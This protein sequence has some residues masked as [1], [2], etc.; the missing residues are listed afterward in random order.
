MVE[1]G[2]FFCKPSLRK[3]L[4]IIVEEEYFKDDS[5]IQRAI[6]KDHSLTG[7]VIYYNSNNIDHNKKIFFEE[8]FNFREKQK[9][10]IEIQIEDKLIALYFFF[11]KLFV[12]GKV[13]RK[14]LKN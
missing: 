8:I 4:L 10:R 9:H 7:K 11:Y 14:L 1:T 6:L 12:N 3:K 2:A 5:F 13:K